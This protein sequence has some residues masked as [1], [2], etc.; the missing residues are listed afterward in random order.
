VEFADVLLISK[1]DLVEQSELDRLVAILKTLSTQARI[2]P[3]AN[4]KVNADDVLNTRLFDFERAQESPG[5]LKEI[6]G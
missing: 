2:I 4:G 1:T 5:W 6:R 3:I